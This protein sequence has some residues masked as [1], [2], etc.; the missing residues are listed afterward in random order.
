MGPSCSS[1]RRRA[2]R[3]STFPDA[4]RGGSLA[5]GLDQSGNRGTDQ[6]AGDVTRESWQEP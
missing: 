4:D 5:W 3:A 1:H 6:Q 2:S